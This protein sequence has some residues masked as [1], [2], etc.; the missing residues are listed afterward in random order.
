MPAGPVPPFPAELIDSARM[1]NLLQE[2]QAQF[3]FIVIDSPPILPIAD[4]RSLSSLAEATVLVA[5]AGRTTR[6]A[7]L[8]AYEILLKHAKDKRVPSI[9]VVLNGVSLHSA[10]YY[11]FYGYYGD[12]NTAYYAEGGQK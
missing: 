8:R 7:L 6:V 3:D 10:G 1:E 4:A 11:G 5:R 9:G 2:W 12:K